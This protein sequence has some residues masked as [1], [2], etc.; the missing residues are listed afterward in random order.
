MARRPKIVLLWTQFAAYHVDRCEA[1]ARRFDGRADIV[2]I[3]MASR[4]QQ[5]AWQP[6]AQIAG[7][8][9]LTLFGDARLEDISSWRRLR[10]IFKHARGADWLISG[11]SSGH[12]VMIALSLILP[13]FGTRMIMQSDS[14]FDD[15]ERRWWREALKSVLY[16]PYRGAIV[17]GL[18]A[19]DFMRFLGFRR[20]P[21]LPG[22]DTVGTA[23]V[24]AQSGG[25]LAQDAADFAARPFVFV[26]RFVAKKNLPVLIEAYARYCALVGSGVGPEAGLGSGPA[27]RQLVL[28]GAGEAQ[29]AIEAQIA[30]LGLGAQVVFPGFLDAGGVARA[31][32]SAAALVLPS[33]EEQWGLVVN[34]A[35]ACGVPVI[36]SENV[37]SR[38]ALVDNLVNGYVVPARSAASLARALLAIGADEAQ[39]RAMARASAQRIWLAD[40]ERFADAVEMLVDGPGSPAAAQV[41]KFRRLLERSEEPA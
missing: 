33:T 34:E 8:R 29:P 9:K 20:R 11:E 10:A 24:L 37:G 21:V 30:R 31:I 39:W 25:V 18:R 13:L 38:D 19:R 14:K 36:V 16:L 32:G 28:V 22:C 4:S 1:L 41:D 7:C 17:G 2:A 12:P 23:R 35:I 5:Y 26:A 6:S 15:F 3:E 27:P 40:V